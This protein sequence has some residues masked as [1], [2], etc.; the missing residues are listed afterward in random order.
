MEAL[1]LLWERAVRP[2]RAF[3]ERCL[4]APG[5]GDSVKEML[6]LRAPI[7][8][9]GSVLAYLSFQ[10]FYARI[11]SPDSEVWRFIVARAPDS[12]DPADLNAALAKLPELPTLHAMLPWLLLLAPLAVLSLWLHDATFDHMGLWLL[13]G[14]KER[15]GFRASL[16]A[17]SEAL[18]VGALGAAVGLIA[19]LPGMGIALGL[20]LAPVAIYFWILRGY[21]LAAWHGCPPWKGIVATLLNIVLA[22]AM[23]LLMLLACVVMVLVLEGV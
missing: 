21:A 10:G 22:G 16:V 23:L 4:E 11:A 14:L 17:D 8:F 7:A 12:V 20:L 2:S 13:G 1:R 18:K 3:R 9:L 19:D 5:L 15:R 6:L